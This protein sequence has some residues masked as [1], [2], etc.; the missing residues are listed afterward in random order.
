[1]SATTFTASTTTSAL[2]LSPREVA[3][4]RESGFLVIDAPRIDTIEIALCR[5]VLERLMQRQIGR[6]QG[7]YIDLGGGDASPQIDPSPQILSPSFYARELR[8]LSFRPRAL[9]IARQLLGS[10]ACFAGDH[11]VLKPAGLGAATPWHQDE[12][13]RDPDFDYEEISLWIALNDV[14]G[15]GSPMAYIPG[16]HRRGVLPHRIRADDRAGQTLECYAGFDP[17]AATVCP[18]P[19]GAMIVH[20]VRTV[21]G[22]PA[23]RSLTPRCAYILSYLRPPTPRRTKR[24]FPWLEQLRRTN[25]SRRK[26][27]LLRGGVFIEVLRILRSDR[28][29]DRHFLSGFLRRRVKSLTAWW[30]RR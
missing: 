4:F 7:R 14:S 11:A 9:A 13:F 5:R 23:N 26:Q 12:A 19:A 24:E 8:R 16:S 29:A 17:A 18:I 21:H 6:E 20:H 28:Y 1:M 3:C 30:R 22:A 27:F 25:R 15:D 10:D 2:P